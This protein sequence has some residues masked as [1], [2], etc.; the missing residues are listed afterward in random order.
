[1]SV[2]SYEGKRV[3]IVGCFSG[4]GEAVA[5]EV[6]RLGGEVHGVD[7]RQSPVDLASF[8]QLDLKDAQAADAVVEA[9]GGQIDCL[10]NCAGLP[11]TFPAI[12]VMKVNFIGMR[13]WTERWLPQI[14]K[15]GAVCT[16]ASNAA[17]RFQER[18]EVTKD[19]N[20]T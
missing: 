8:H 4:I 1:M 2:W 7:V 3:V 20:A 16:I 6:V 14:N 19:L 5:R 12:D 13:H 17:Y 11:Q 15:G 9:I 18:L 10:F